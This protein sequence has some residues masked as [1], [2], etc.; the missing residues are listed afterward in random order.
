MIPGRYWYDTRS[1]HRWY[2]GRYPEKSTSGGCASGAKGPMEAGARSAPYLIGNARRATDRQSH[3]ARGVFQS[4]ATTVPNST[5]SQSPPRPL[6]NLLPNSST[7]PQRTPWPDSSPP[8]PSSALAPRSLVTASP[9]PPAMLPSPSR[10]RTPHCVPPLAPP[11]LQS[12]LGYGTC[13]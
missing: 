1:I 11:P 5:A 10:Y 7:K 4:A 13:R 3:V 9:P 8:P 12:H 6:R 2:S